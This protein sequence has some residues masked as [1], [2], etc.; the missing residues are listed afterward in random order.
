MIRLAFLA[1]A[2]LLV[3]LALADALPPPTEHSAT[4]LRLFGLW[5]EQACRSGPAERHST[6]CELRTIAFGEDTIAVLSMTSVHDVRHAA[7]TAGTWSE[8]SSDASGAVIHSDLDSNNWQISFTDK[9]SFVIKG[10]GNWPDAT[11]KRAWAP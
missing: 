10:S 7:A 4:Q 6:P 5:Q 3:P 2:S 1:P 8:V 9:D 11:F